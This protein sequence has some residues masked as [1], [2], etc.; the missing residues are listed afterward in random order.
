M[1]YVARQGVTSVHNMGTWDDLATF[2]RAHR[3]GSL[4]T[5]IYAVVPI[6]TWERLRDT[7]AARGHGDAW[8]RIGGLKGFVDGSLGS[9]TAAFLQ[10]F[11]DSPRDSGLLVNTEHDL[12]SWTSGADRAGLQVMVHAI[13]DRA[14]RMQLGIFERVERENGNRDRRFRIEHAQH[15]APADIPR[16]TSLG[17]IASMQPYHAIDDGRWADRV[18]GAE[19]A[20]TTYA[21]R[22]LRDAGARLAFGSD[23]FVAPPTPLEGIYAAATRRTLDD[24]NPDGW[25]PEQKIT[26]EDALRAYTIGGAY[27]SFDEGDKG[28]LERGKLADFVLIDHDL[29]RVAPETIRDAKVTMT[30]V[31][32]RIVFDRTATQGGQ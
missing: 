2:E 10:P 1:R 13:G 30:V 8:V 12:Y 3:A 18:I 9:H 19:R 4:I 22:S 5:R 6:S 11:S 17:V 7:V 29:T 27:A 14:I 20:R 16:F 25:V 24:R 28:S 26:V 15:I 21:F 32:G 23:W 31:G